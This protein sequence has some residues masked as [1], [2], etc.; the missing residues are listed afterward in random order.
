MIYIH[1]ELSRLLDA[2]SMDGIDFQNKIRK[3]MDG[4]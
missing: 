1:G 2:K 4:W 3:W